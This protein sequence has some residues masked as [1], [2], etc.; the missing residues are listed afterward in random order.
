MHRQSDLRKLIITHSRMH[1]IK[2]LHDKM[3]LPSQTSIMRVSVRMDYSTFR[4]VHK[5]EI[6]SILKLYVADLHSYLPLS[7]Q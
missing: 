1:T 7:T 3:L 6:P 4:H 5:H 2:T